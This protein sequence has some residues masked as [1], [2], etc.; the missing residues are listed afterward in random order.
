[1]NNAEKDRI[2]RLRR[3]GPGRRDSYSPWVTVR[4]FSSNGLSLRVPGRASGRVV[5]L[6]SL[7]ELGAFLL[8]DFDPDVVD[9]REQF[10]LLGLP[11]TRALAKR[12]HLRHP[13]PSSRARRGSERHV[14]TTDLVVTRVTRS[15]AEDRAIA[16]KPRRSLERRSVVSRLII[17][18]AYW[19]KRGV[20]FQILTD[21]HLDPTLTGN[22]RWLAPFG[23]RAE[24]QPLP[25]VTPE[26]ESTA[27]RFLR[28]SDAPLS[29]TCQGLDQTLEFPLGTALGLVRRRL[30]TRHWEAD[31]AAAPLPNGRLAGLRRGGGFKP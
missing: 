28:E 7:L 12:L 16:V 24:A 30:A 18:G 25:G 20:P 21:R 14:L 1:M 22:L 23:P 31:L 29:G 17:E 4:G 2:E 8:H 11:D 3:E 10:P 6:F 5:H 26:A 15:G 13:R 27:F 9:I 19:A